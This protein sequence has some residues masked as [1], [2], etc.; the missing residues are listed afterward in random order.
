MRPSRKMQRLC[1]SPLRRQCLSPPK[2]ADGINCASSPTPT[3]DHMHTQPSNTE[4]FRPGSIR[5]DFGCNIAPCN[6][7]NA[8]QR[9]SHLVVRLVWRIARNAQ[10]LPLAAS[11]T[12]G[13]QNQQSKA[14]K[15]KPAKQNQQSKTSKAKPAKVDRHASCGMSSAR[16]SFPQQPPHPHPPSE[17]SSSNRRLR[18]GLLRRRRVTGQC[19]CRRR[20]TPQ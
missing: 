20:Q 10:T 14:S 13:R 16:L 8:P 6:G 7:P 5:S 12:D 2:G 17:R 15:A 1:E 19:R 9:C 18:R 3:A 11:L 4:L